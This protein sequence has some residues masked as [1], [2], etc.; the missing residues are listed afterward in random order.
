MR[1]YKFQNH[2]GQT[3]ST[4]TP[5]RETLVLYDS[6]NS[7]SDLSQLA[8]K[9]IIDNNGDKIDVTKLLRQNLTYSQRLSTRF[10]NI[11]DIS[12]FL[13]SDTSQAFFIAS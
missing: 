11:P 12:V 2:Y 7:K 3:L 8:E 9:N 1:P 10:Q 4:R 6:D 13:K 5:D